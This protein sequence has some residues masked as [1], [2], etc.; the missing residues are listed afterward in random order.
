MNQAEMRAAHRGRWLAVLCG[1][2]AAGIYVAATDRP[3]D[4]RAPRTSARANPSDSPTPGHIAG[5]RF[6]QVRVINEQIEAQWLANRIKPSARCTDYEF[7]RRASLDI[8]GRIATPKE[9]DDFFSKHSRETRRGWLIDHLLASEE[10]A[11]NWANI[12][13][14]WLLTRSGAARYHEEMQRWLEAQLLSENFRYDR[15]VHDLIT[16]KGKSSDNGAVTFICSHMGLANPPETVS[17]QG[18]FDFVPLTSRITRLFLGLQTQC[19]QCHDHPFFPQARRQSQFWGIDAF[20]RQVKATPAMR[21]LQRRL[22]APELTLSENT[23]LNKEGEVFY[24]DRKA[25]VHLAKPTWLFPGKDGRPVRAD[26]EKPRREQLAELVTSSEFFPKAYVNRMWGHFFGRGFTN[27]GPV[28]DFGEHNPITHPMLPTDL[29]AQLHKLKGAVP[30]ELADELKK[31]DE[32]QD[33]PHLLDYLANEFKKYNYDPK[34]LIR[35]ICNSE[36]YQLSTVAN[37]TNAKADTEPFFSRMGLKAMTPEQLFESLWMATQGQPKPGENL[38]GK[39]KMR[40]DWM[41]SLIVNF[42]DDEGNEANFNG[43]VIQALML[44]NGK[45]MND[46]VS[47]RNQG[48]VSRIAYDKKTHRWRGR[49]VILHDLYLTALNRPPTAREKTVVANEIKFMMQGRVKGDLL[50]LYQDIFWA[51]LNSN[52]FMLNH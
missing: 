3:A 41:N 32:D 27:P 23:D 40:D 50:S 51:L 28:D 4:A 33:K 26:L 15:M 16:A 29:I 19:T 37:A 48:M 46:Q 12:W 31:Y 11:R 22:P 2:A 39:A 8:I 49:D 36:A 42:G 21:V 52:E 10:Y 20:F 38:S 34:Q 7:I 5:V 18:E 35:W 44:M 6:D 13:S 43:T 14:V 9:L 25:T 24:E 17:E 1:L 30:D 45:Q 47:D